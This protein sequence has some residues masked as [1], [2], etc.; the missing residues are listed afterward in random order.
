MWPDRRGRIRSSAS[1]VPFMTPCRFTS[2]ILR[3][4]S[5]SSSANG[6]P[7][8]MIPALFTSTSSGPSS[9]STASTNSANESRST[10]STAKE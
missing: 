10:T 4:V 7:T 6:Q 2:T 1:F 9:R 3:V 5:S 8:S